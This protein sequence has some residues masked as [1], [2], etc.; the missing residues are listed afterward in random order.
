[1]NQAIPR[2]GV[3]LPSEF[4]RQQIFNRLQTISSVTAWRRVLDFYQAW[5]I[6]TEKSVHEA[7]ELGWAASTSLPGSELLLIQKGLAHCKKGV[8]RL[9]SGDKRVFKF[10]AN[11]DFAMAFNILSHWRKM[12][13]RIE[14][15]ENGIDELHTPLW[16]KF[17]EAVI[18]AHLTWCECSM[19]IL[20]TRYKYRPG[21]TLY[22]DWLKAELK[23][24]SFPA[25]LEEVPDPIQNTF[26]RT[27]AYT[28]CSG[29]WEPIEVLHRKASLMNLFSRE[30]TPLPPFKIM[31][32]MNYLHGNSKTPQIAVETS[33]DNIDVDT[34]WRLLWRDDRYTDGGIPES[35][36]YYR[37]SEPAKSGDAA[38]G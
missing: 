33:T 18:D 29:I 3:M 10:D 31:G 1:M 34:T 6:A 16:G 25:V 26:V 2:A 19:D 13:T 7:R 36:A 37:F 30:A 9:S 17:T 11:G 22:G 27:N 35:E 5:A 24:I 23:N 38:S 8:E 32:A 12:I 4:E 15:G 28:P 21:L 14:E 20:E